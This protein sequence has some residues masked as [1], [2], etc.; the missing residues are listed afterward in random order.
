MNSFFIYKVDL[1]KQHS[2]VLVCYVASLGFDLNDFTES[3]KKTFENSP[4]SQELVI[5]S[6]EYN[7]DVIEKKLLNNDF[8]KKILKEKINNYQIL[9]IHAGFLNVQGDIE[10]RSYLDKLSNS[11]FSLNSSYRNLVEKGFIHIF[12]K[13]NLVMESSANYHFVKPSGKHTNK[14]I[15]AANIMESGAEISFIAIHL[16]EKIHHQIDNIYTDTAGIFPVAYELFAIYNRFKHPCLGFI[17]SFASYEGLASYNFKGNSK[18]LVLISASTSNDLAR[19]LNSYIGLEKATILSLFS[20]AY[21]VDDRQTLVSFKHYSDSYKLDMFSNFSSQKE[22]ECELCLYEHSIPLSLSNSQF[23]FEVPNTELYLPLAKDSNSTL[24]QLISSYKDTG[25]FKCLYD[26]LSGQT[27]PVP[28]YFIDLSKLTLTD[29]FKNDVRNTIIRSFPLST[30]L[31]V[32]ANDQGAKELALLVQQAASDLGKNVSVVPISQ[33]QTK[34][35]KEGIVVIAGSIQSGK[36]L[37]D[38][39]RKL[40]KHEKLPITYLVGFAKYNDP[41]SYS[42]LKNDLVFNNGNKS[43][44]RHKFVAIREVM[45][46]INEHRI[47]SW[48]REKEILK[49]IAAI[50][51]FP[52]KHLQ[53][54]G[55]R[56]KFLRRANSPEVQGVG[57]VL[58]YSRPDNTEMK[59]GPTF[60]FWNERDTKEVFSHQATVYYTISSLLQSLRYPSQERPMAPLGGGYIVKQLNP[61]LFDRFNEGIIHASFLRAAK[62]R[63]LDYSAD[64]ASSSI[65]GSL[66]IRMLNEP[67]NDTSEGLPEFLM[68]LCTK[69]LQIRSD[70]LAA[71]ETITLDAEKY[72]MSWILLEYAKGV[73][74]NKQLESITDATIPF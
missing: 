12:V 46:P 61:L 27:T 65:I 17:D 67:D 40:R 15:K 48:E 41:V 5:I 39:S 74:F 42:K 62:P 37:L 68:A 18:T 49:K 73:L 2:N 66:I 21:D 43:L 44:G 29:D 57:E 14:F 51:S 30:D 3:I 45:L 52:Q 60:A 59:L 23:V 28:E 16:L 69:K 7:R 8:A 35:P 47:N 58:F 9:N 25:V 24:K 38:I 20:S 31:I 72:P 4:F 22:H 63:E 56:E 32:Y 71:M 26:G 33:F 6:A 36:S 13:R 70:H 1:S 11:S 54:I 50:S 19:E 10:C 64:D 55:A 34:E 53:L